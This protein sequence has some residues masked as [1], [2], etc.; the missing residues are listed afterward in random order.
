MSDISSETSQRLLEAAGEIFAEKGFHGATIREI[1]ERAKANIAAVNYHFHD[2]EGLY[3]RVLDFWARQ[4]EDKFPPDAGLGPDATPEER[5]TVFIR[6]FLLR[7]LD[8]TRPAWFSRLLAHEMLAPTIALD[9]LIN[10][11]FR[12]QFERLAEIVRAL[13][14]PSA[15]PELVLLCCRSILGQ[16]LYYYHAKPAIQRMTPDFK[17]EPADLER[18]AAHIARFSL[19][20]LRQLS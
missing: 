14:G 8:P 11:L 19:G 9:R 6:S 7:V 18:V 12:P 13:L 10:D 2:K 1:C 20:A 17:Y 16:C 3:A 5:L 4:G 15:S